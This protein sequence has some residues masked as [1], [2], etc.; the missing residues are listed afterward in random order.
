MTGPNPA[1]EQPPT[2]QEAAMVAQEAIAVFAEMV[3]GRHRL[4]GFAHPDTLAGLG[5]LAGVLEAAGRTEEALA[6]YEVT[7][8]GHERAL[9]TDHPDTLA[10]RADLAHVLQSVGRA[11]EAIALVGA[12]HRGRPGRMMRADDRGTTRRHRHIWPAC[13]AVAGPYANLSHYRRTRS[14]TTAPRIRPW[15]MADG[16]PY[17]QGTV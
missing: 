7:L 14:T 10:T 12:S 15:R 11:H 13:A 6:L 5:L 4:L 3:L 2:A 1:A 16:A 9:G 17:R 8:A